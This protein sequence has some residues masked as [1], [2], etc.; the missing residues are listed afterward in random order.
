[1]KRLLLVILAGAALVGTAA[2]SGPPG[3]VAPQPRGTAPPGM[4]PVPVGPKHD[5]SAKPGARPGEGGDEAEEGEAG[6]FRRRSPGMAD[7]FL[8][9]GNFRAAAAAFERELKSNPTS[10]ATHIGLARAYARIGRCPEAL[11]H[12]WPYVDSRPFGDEAALA[13]AVCSGRLGL[14]E[15]AL[16]FD[17][18]A[19]A[20]DRTNARAL[21][22]YALD[23]DL[24]GRLW[25]RDEVLDELYLSKPDRDASLYAR[26]VIAL[27]HGDLDEFDL[28]MATWPVDSDTRVSR[29]R[30]L[31]QSWLDSDLPEQAVAEIEKLK[32]F[33]RGIAA[34]EI[35]AEALRRMGELTDAKD[36]LESR[37]TRRAHGADIDAVRARVSVDTGDLADAQALLDEYDRSDEPEVLASLWYLA[38]SRGQDELMA[39]YAEEYEAVRQSP[40]RVLEKL[41][42]VPERF[43]AAPAPR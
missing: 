21:T 3:F 6:G 19:V 29:V 4:R 37:L 31:A 38:R 41:V 25:E 18:I 42:P 27:R 12:F 33:T 11:D 2:A 1:M 36:G 9:S 24:A 39:R 20:R 17:Q 23:L 35:R 28:L 8:S 15:D 16:Y 13:A 26:A 5:P 10:P 14:L 30:L 40:H 32:V 22:N 43:G 34:R 7:G